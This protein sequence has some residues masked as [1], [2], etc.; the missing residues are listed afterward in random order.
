MRQEPLSCFNV[1]LYVLCCEPLELVPGKVTFHFVCNQL[2]TRFWKFVAVEVRK[3]ST[4]FIYF[5]GP[6][7]K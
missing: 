4:R 1:A 6:N 2:I 3:N 5:R 7:R